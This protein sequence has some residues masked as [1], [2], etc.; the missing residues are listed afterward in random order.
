MNNIPNV[1]N[2]SRFV[3]FRYWLI[4][5]IAG[6]SS[7]IL[8]VRF[9]IVDQRNNEPLAVNGDFSGLHASNVGF[10]FRNGQILSVTQRVAK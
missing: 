7:I 8:N 4:R 3:N 10:P 5:V 9:D 6:R 1:S 2:A